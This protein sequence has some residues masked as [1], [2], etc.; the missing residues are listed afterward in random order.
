MLENAYISALKT[1]KLPGLL[2]GPWTPAADNWL[3]SCD[4]TPSPQQLLALEAGD[5]LDQILDPHL[6]QIKWILQNNT[7]YSKLKMALPLK[8]TLQLPS[9]LLLYW[10]PGGAQVHQLGIIRCKWCLLFV[11]CFF[12]APIGHVFKKHSC[13]NCVGRRINHFSIQSVSLVMSKIITLVVLEIIFCV[14]FSIFMI[15]HC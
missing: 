15:F 11:K 10:P 9:K 1:Q 14:W 12:W 3:Y 13:F 6:V 5:P 4:S 8:N 7:A 2:C